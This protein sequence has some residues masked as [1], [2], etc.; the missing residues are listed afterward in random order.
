MPI[1]EN[2]ELSSLSTNMDYQRKVMEHV[3]VELQAKPPLQI[4]T[5]MIK[6]LVHNFHRSNQ[7]R[8]RQN[9]TGGTAN[10]VVGFLRLFLCVIT[11]FTIPSILLCKW[12]KIMLQTEGTTARE[13]NLLTNRGRQPPNTARR[14]A[15]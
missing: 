13:R 6:N 2:H 7:V 15:L 9:T 12:K 14:V 1:P 3:K 4:D 5:A 8:P 10:N 11:F